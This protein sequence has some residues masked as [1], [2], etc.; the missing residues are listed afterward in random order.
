MP[1]HRN[2]QA[3]STTNPLEES[4]EDALNPAQPLPLF[5]PMDRPE[6]FPISALGKVIAPAVLAVADQTQAPDALCA[7]TALAAVSL[8]TY[9][10]ADIVLPI[11]MGQPRPLS[12]FLWTIAD[13]GER[14]SA[15]ETLVMQPVIERERELREAARGDVHAFVPML[16]CEETTDKG[17]LALLDEGQSA[18]GII[19][20][21]GSQFVAGKGQSTKENLARASLLSALW[22]GRP[23]K[24]VRARSHPVILAGRRVVMHL[25]TQTDDAAR[26][27][28]YRQL[29]EPLLARCL[30]SRPDSTMGMRL[31][32]LPPSQPPPALSLF[33]DRMRQHLARPPMLAPDSRYE[34][35]LPGLR[36]DDE[37]IALFHEFADTIEPA[38]K[39]GGDFADLRAFASKL[40]E[41]AARIAGTLTLFETPEATHIDGERMKRG[42]EIA[43]WFATEAVRLCGAKALD[44]DHTD[45]E[46]LRIWLTTRWELDVIGLPD[47]VQRGPTCAR[48]TER[49][50]VLMGILER[51]EWVRP[52]PSGA[53]VGPNYRREAFAIVKAL[54]S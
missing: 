29:N 47:V 35:H 50:R 7:C 26:M 18:I 17:L 44:G 13:S 1:D 43:Q 38:M 12:L 3:R 23:I 37:A 16:I 31:R 34:H 14:Q 25:T 33:H 53:W 15:V 4:T 5:W 2:S 22:D 46:K 8:A 52:K 24:R 9:T 42:I 28:G 54:P 6:P 10:T 48:F 51:H 45:A 30:L 41:H 40:A 11:D 19:S 49:A 39:A 27:L 32:R 36:C 21:E 20:A